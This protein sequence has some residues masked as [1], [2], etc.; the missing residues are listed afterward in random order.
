MEQH[1]N[2][3]NENLI[4]DPHL[5]PASV[6]KKNLTLSLNKSTSLFNSDSKTIYSFVSSGKI[7][8]KEQEGRDLSPT[9]S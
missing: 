8:K 6:L 1:D 2:D 7:M 9:S 4:K 5:Y 3:E